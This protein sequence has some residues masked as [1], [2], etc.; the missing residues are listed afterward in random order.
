MA[1]ELPPCQAAA[2]PLTSL[3]GCLPAA[4]A[5]ASGPALRF[6]LPSGAVSGLQVAP[7]YQLVSPCDRILAVI[8]AAT[9]S[10]YL[11]ASY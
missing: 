7:P 9:L 3:L 11:P 6:A 8:W 5:S 10:I 2:R 1:G 4:C